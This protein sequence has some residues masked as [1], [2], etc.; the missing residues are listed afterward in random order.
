[1]EAEFIPGPADR[2]IVLLQDCMTALGDTNQALTHKLRKVV[3]YV[4]EIQSA[5]MKKQECIKENEREAEK[6]LLKKLE[7]SCQEKAV[8]KMQ[9]TELKAKLKEYRDKIAVLKK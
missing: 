7:A 8:L 6:A 9:N 1:M 3:T 4:R 5:E 2:A